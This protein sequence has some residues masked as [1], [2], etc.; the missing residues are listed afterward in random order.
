MRM[1]LEVK[2]HKE[3]NE[4]LQFLRNIN[5]YHPSFDK[6]TEAELSN[7]I[8]AIKQ[9]RNL[10]FWHDGFSIF[11]H[12]HLMIMVACMFDPAVYLTGQEYFNLYGKHINI[13]SV[14]ET[15][16]LYIL[17]RCR[18][19]DSQLLYSSERLDDILNLKDDVE[20]NGA[21]VHDIA[22]IFKGDYPACQLEA[23]HQKNGDYFLLAMP[24]KCQN[25]L[26]FSLH[27]ITTKFLI[28]RSH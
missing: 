17:A 22:R 4:M 2:N 8:T 20:Y 13:Q 24:T 18:S 12:S 23:G 7:K 3:K 19:D 11:N 21:K 10:M 1:Y 16:Y 28:R 6:L 26:K 14:I 5:E 9:T 27:N 25:V 15:P